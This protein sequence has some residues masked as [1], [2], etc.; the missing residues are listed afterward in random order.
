MRALGRFILRCL[1]RYQ[2]WANEDWLRDCRR[3]GCLSIGHLREV[4][5]QQQALRVRLAILEK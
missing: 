3:D 4:E 1:V 2:L 5:K